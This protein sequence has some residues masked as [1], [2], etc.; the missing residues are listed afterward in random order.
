MKTKIEEGYCTSRA[1]NCKHDDSSCPDDSEADGPGGG[2]AKPNAYQMPSKK[3]SWHKVFKNKKSSKYISKSESRD[4]DDVR[5]EKSQ[6]CSIGTIASKAIGTAIANIKKQPITGLTVGGRKFQ[7][8]QVIK[9][10][11]V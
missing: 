11:Q 6:A 9:N 2:K 7:Q 5:L 8:S 10:V 3:H 1:S 4:S